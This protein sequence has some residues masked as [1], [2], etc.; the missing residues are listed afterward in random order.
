MCIKVFRVVLYTY[1]YGI[2]ASSVH[3]YVCY[4]FESK[5]SRE[6]ACAQRCAYVLTKVHIEEEKNRV[7]ELLQSLSHFFHTHLKVFLFLRKYNNN[8]PCVYTLHTVTIVKRQRYFR[9][10]NSFSLS[11]VHTTIFFSV[12]IVGFIQTELNSH[13]FKLRWVWSWRKNSYYY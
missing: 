11:R 2:V 12:L 8:D 13:Q 9:Y 1:I 6:N 4:L 3:V 7:L 5:D 10:S